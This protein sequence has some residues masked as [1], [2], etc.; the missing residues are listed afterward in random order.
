[1]NEHICDY[2]ASTAH[3]YHRKCVGGCVPVVQMSLM[4]AVTQVLMATWPHWFSHVEAHTRALQR[5]KVSVGGALAPV[6][7][8]EMFW[9]ASQQMKSAGVKTLPLSHFLCWEPHMLMIS[10]NTSHHLTHQTVALL[11]DSTD[12]KKKWSALNPSLS[13]PHPPPHPSPLPPFLTPLFIHPVFAATCSL[14]LFRDAIFSSHSSHCTVPSAHRSDG[15]IPA[16]FSLL[17]LLL[18][19]Q[20]SLNWR[21]R[22]WWRGGCFSSGV[23]LMSRDWKSMAPVVACRVLDDSGCPNINVGP[24][25][26]RVGEQ[27]E[28]AMLSVH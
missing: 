1:M 21:K 15:R 11:T 12:A 20:L 9:P 16:G 22:G 18:W 2:P 25:H 24:I 6:T 10:L 13:P 17:F 3:Y 19:A 5:S 23:M 28:E 8:T 7:D 27:Y 4:D 14:P 26:R